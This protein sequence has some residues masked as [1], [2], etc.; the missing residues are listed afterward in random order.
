MPDLS[1]WMAEFARRRSPEV[2]GRQKQRVSCGG[3]SWRISNRCSRRLDQ[4]ALLVALGV[5]LRQ[6]RET[7]A[8][9]RKDERLFGIGDRLGHD[10]PRA[11]G[12]LVHT[13]QLFGP[14]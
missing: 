14:A 9:G 8:H 4:P 2:P 13:P 11:I 6:R 1:T 10:A 12:K 3:S 7:A 5:E